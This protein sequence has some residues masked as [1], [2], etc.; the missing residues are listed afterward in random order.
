M[1]VYRT[2]SEKE[3]VNVLFGEEM[4]PKVQRSSKCFVRRGNEYVHAGEKCFYGFC[5]FVDKLYWYRIESHILL[6][7]DV[8][9]E[10]IL[11][12]GYGLYSTPLYNNF[13]C[14]KD[15]GKFLS[16]GE[17]GLIRNSLF[18]DFKLSEVY[19]SSYNSSNITN[20]YFMNGCNTCHYLGNSQDLYSTNLLSDY[21]FVLIHNICSYLRNK[22][23]LRWKK[24]YSFDMKMPWCK[25]ISLRFIKNF[26][27]SVIP[28]KEDIFKMF[29][30][31]GK[32]DNLESFLA[33]SHD[34]EIAPEV[35]WNFF[36]EMFKNDD[37]YKFC[38][39]S[40]GNLSS[41][42]IDVV[43]DVFEYDSSRRKLA[44]EYGWE[45]PELLDRDVINVF[46]YSLFKGL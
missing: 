8:N 38:N 32:V 17:Y 34:F 31:Y 10:Q 28:E 42:M 2:V 37:C 6:E 30:Y 33:K 35:L 16:E 36:Q 14:D 1:K 39:L 40:E 45:A 41:K 26:L 7:L 25:D 9:E 11:H 24:L 18:K 44:Q 5:C 21:I 23:D 4:V 3:F 46:I 20:V 27:I 12:R 19:L 22:D 29:S 13:V 43:E 15:G